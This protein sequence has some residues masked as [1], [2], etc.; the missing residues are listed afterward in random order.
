M[1]V[2][3]SGA[4]TAEEITINKDGIS[5]LGS[6]VFTAE[7]YLIHADALRLQEGIIYIEDG[8]IRSNQGEVSVQ[9]AEID[10]E[11]GTIK[12]SEGRWT[13]CVC[14]NPYIIESEK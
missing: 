13:R 3:E 12:A 7:D 1:L 6:V 4:L 10:I 14:E 8:W 9:T 11:S 2:G 5:A